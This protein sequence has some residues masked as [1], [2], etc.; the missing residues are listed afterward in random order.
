M[1]IL[2]HLRGHLRGEAEKKP[3]EEVKDI[4]WNHQTVWNQVVEL[5]GF[6]EKNKKGSIREVINAAIGLVAQSDRPFY[7]GGIKPAK[8]IDA[9]P[10]PDDKAPRHTRMAYLL[11]E[12]IAQA[13]FIEPALLTGRTAELTV[14][15]GEK[16]GKVVFAAISRLFKEIGASKKRIEG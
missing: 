11:L 10:K 14:T 13:G 12:Q 9:I 16:M 4:L 7:F 15:V 1:N 8:W 2:K 5:L 3:H 6:D